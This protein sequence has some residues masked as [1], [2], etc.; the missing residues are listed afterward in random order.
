[1]DPDAY[2]CQLADVFNGI[3]VH[4][5]TIS[6][7]IAIVLAGLLLLVSGFASAS[8]IAF[9]SLSPSDLSA[10]DEKKHPSDEKISKLLEDTE[11]LLATILITNN[12]V[13]VTIIMLCNFFFMS[14][15]EFH[16][17]IA[18]FLI[19]TVILTFLLLLFGEIMPK[20]YSAQKTLAF[21][22]FSAPGIWMFRSLFYPVASMLVR[23]TS[24]LNKHFARKNH[25]ISVDE[26]SHALELTDK[27][28]LKEENNILEGIIRFGGETAK[29]VMTSR[30]DVVDLDIRTP[31]KDVLQCIIENAY[32]RIPIY[33]ENRDNI[34][35]ILYIKDL[36]PHL[37]K[38]DFRW[39]SLIR[40]AY[41]VPETK[42][43]DDLLRDFQA[44]KI[45]IAIVVD[46]FGGTSGIVTMEDII[47]EI[48][49][50]IHD[51]YDDEER[52][53]A[54][55]NDHTWVFEAKTQLTDFYKI[56]KVDEEVFDEVAGD[57]DTLAG[58]LLELKGEFPALHER[59]TYDHYEFEV[60]EMDNRR[61]LKVKFTINTPP[62]DSD[63]KD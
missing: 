5:P 57:S 4:S 20:I 47:E 49:G 58:L 42:M 63:K 10:I 59:V 54:V 17:P 30:L 23:S 28:E 44:N 62:S 1:M 9:F 48:V 37:N 19:L 27:E 3:S 36:L 39:Q 7:I 21:C 16:S 53:Y 55:L 46:E 22:R 52:T 12:F 6:A 35:G 56:T 11:R 50:E 33:S 41:F 31:F 34:K 14:V 24:F 13:N 15:F 25:N 29:E 60:L 51:E 2:L 18:E 45:H 26:L 38:V 43:I 40:P 32:S 8:E 61:I